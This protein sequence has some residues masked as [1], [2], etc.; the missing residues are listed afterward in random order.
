MTDILKKDYA[1]V[2]GYTYFVVSTGSMSGTIE[3]ND[4]IFVK[5]D[6]DVKIND[7]ITYKNE[8]GDIITHRLV[9]I[10]GDKLIAQGDV[11]NIQDD[12]ITREQ[13]IGKVS[14]IVSPSFILKCVATFLILFILLALFNFDSIMEKY[15]VKGGKEKRNKNTTAV[16]EELFKTKEVK[17]DRSSGLTVTIPLKELEKIKLLHEKETEEEEIEVLELEEVIDI[18][19]NNIITKEKNSSKERE[20]ELLEQVSNLLRI[21]NDTLTTARINKKWLT[22]YQY[23]YKLTH[24]L[25][26]NDNVELIE[27]IEHPPFKEIYDYDLEKA[28]L[29]ENLRNKIYDMPIYVFLRILAFAVLYND[30]QFFDGV[31]KIMKYKIQIDKNNHFREVKKSDVYGRK[32]LKNLILFMQK[33]SLKYDNKNVFELERVEKIVKLKSYVNN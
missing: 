3:V 24:I 4:I 7:V 29:Y 6:D 28:G 13:V 10:V 5:I 21:K 11:N 17:E 23:V 15:I 12:P 22:K 8:N 33:I 9:Q 19:G 2:F 26:I 20:K 1:N 30:E 16:P 14:L 25:M 31:F 18:D 27:A 32:Q